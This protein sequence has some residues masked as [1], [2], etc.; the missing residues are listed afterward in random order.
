MTEMV[1]NDDGSQ[2]IEEELDDLGQRY[3]D[4]SEYEDDLMDGM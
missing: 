3:T 4:D 1:V 2:H